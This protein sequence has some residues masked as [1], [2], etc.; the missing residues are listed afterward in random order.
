VVGRSSLPGSV[1]ALKHPLC[2]GEPRALF[3]RRV[4]RLTKQQFKTRWELV[5]WLTRNRPDIN[6]STPPQL[7]D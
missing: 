1:T 4:E 5:D 2:Y 3:L 6:L 7:A